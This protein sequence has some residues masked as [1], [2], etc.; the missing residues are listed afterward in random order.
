M[1]RVKGD[2]GSNVSL[3]SKGLITIVWEIDVPDGDLQ[4][5]GLQLVRLKERA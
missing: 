2:G 5:E 1:G 4:P 3:K